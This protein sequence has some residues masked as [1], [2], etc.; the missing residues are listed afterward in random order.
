[1]LIS[2]ILFFLN[3]VRNSNISKQASTYLFF[4]ILD[5]TIPF[6]ILPFITREINPEE[7]GTYLL[8]VSLAP[9]LL[10]LM[11]LSVDSSILLSFFKVNKKEF[12]RY[13]S[14]SYLILLSSSIIVGC[15]IYFNK[16]L[17]SSISLLNEDYI[18]L[19]IISC[20][21][22]INSNLAL[23]IFQ[24]KKEP[25]KYGYFSLSLTIIKNT[26]VLIFVFFLKMEAKGLIYAQLISSA[27]FF[28]ISIIVFNY[29]KLLTFNLSWSFT[30]DSLLIGFPLTLH[31]V[32]SWLSTTS[33]RIIIGG[34]MG[35]AAVGSFGVG[36]TIGLVVALVQD[37]F[38]KAFAPYLFEQL[39]IFNN[40]IEIKLINLTYL[41]NISLF[42][43]AIFL[44]VAGYYSLEFIFGNNY[45]GSRNVVIYL[46]LAYAFD[47]MYKMHVN[48]IFFVKK[49][50]LVFIIT[51]ISGLLNIFFSY[52]LVKKF[53][54]SGGAIS[55]CIINLIAYLI[56]W[57]L[58]NKVFPM[59]W[60]NFKK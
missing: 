5:I 35:A 46:C 12:A 55:M 19:L 42:L 52:F 17:F 30:K 8:Y 21:F 59:N 20:L 47:G 34:I 4:K 7:Y 50:H 37:S 11:T 3:S 1:M 27:F 6:L 53:G 15:I 36:A 24:A 33:T 57:V 43:F 10:P 40:E 54:I 60:F 29:Y 49:T 28:I 23:N 58:G 41:Y 45:A 18:S 26:L 56:S 44:G 32:G 25:K 22:Q 31:Q 48:Y 14:S 2:N 51:T 39:K 38:N 16:T 13:F 9:I